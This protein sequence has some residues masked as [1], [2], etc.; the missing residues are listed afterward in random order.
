MQS[1]GEPFQ[2]AEMQEM[3]KA[4]ETIGC[5]EGDEIRYDKYASMLAE[6]TPYA[7]GAAV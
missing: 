1:S 2:E 5:I 4:C 7:P 3:L 6:S